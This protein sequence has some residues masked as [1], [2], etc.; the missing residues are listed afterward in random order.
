MLNAES[1]EECEAGVK[2]HREV[3]LRNA[4]DD[5]Q[6]VT[7]GMKTNTGRDGRT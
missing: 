5:G 2:I 4:G 3:E 6:V 7:E 1:T